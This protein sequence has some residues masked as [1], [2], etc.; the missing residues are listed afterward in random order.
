MLNK[1]ALASFNFQAP[2]ALLFFQCALAVVLVKACELSGLIKPLQPLKRDLITLW[3][4]VNLIFVGMIGS[5]FLA[6]KEVGVGMVT[7][8][9]NLSN[10]VTA[11]GD[12]VLY[13][14]TYT[15]GVWSV[16][17]LMLAS[18]FVGEITHPW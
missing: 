7:V 15:M 12:V 5:S 2:M 4:P 14:K 3:F 9:K 16:L 8:W 6:L 18:A 1:H 17:F 13:K 11:C 10:F